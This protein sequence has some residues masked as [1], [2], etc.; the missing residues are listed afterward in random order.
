MLARQLSL[1]VRQEVSRIDAPSGRNGVS[2]SSGAGPPARDPYRFTD[3]DQAII[4][5]AHQIAGTS[6]A[7]AVRACFGTAAVS[8]A[9]TARAY[10]KALDQATWVIGEL[11]AIIGRLA[12]GAGATMDSER[13][14]PPARCQPE[15][16]RQAEVIRASSASVREGTLLIRPCT[17]EITFTG[18]AG[19][20]LRTAFDDC[21]VTVGPGMTTLRAQ[22]PDQ[23]ALWGLVQR[24]IGFRLE[25]VD[26]HLVA[27]E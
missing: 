27:P 11:L 18:R 3:H 26:L 16:G 23:A 19:D 8:Y 6:G 1:H 4:G 14:E 15:S 13:D 12:D 24:I 20:V 21:M 17:Y 5:R 9:D 10:A 2:A 25:V 22:L 7:A